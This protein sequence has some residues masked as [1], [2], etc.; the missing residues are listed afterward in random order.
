MV[1]KRT[2]I[3]SL[4]EASALQR[5]SI[6]DLR[7]AV[8]ESSQALTASIT[9]L[10]REMGGKIDDLSAQISIL[11]DAVSEQKKTSEL[12]AQ[13]VSD[14]IKVVQQLTARN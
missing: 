12:Q 5:E 7:E 3:D 4:V 11:T 13:N 2:G 8:K 1:E 6:Q 14:L 10:G 9:Q